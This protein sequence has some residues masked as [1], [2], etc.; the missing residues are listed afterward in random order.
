MD[1]FSLSFFSISAVLGQF[2][3]ASTQGKARFFRITFE[4]E[5]LRRIRLYKVIKAKFIM[6]NT[7]QPWN[8]GY[9][10]DKQINSG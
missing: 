3:D 9:M 2:L 1:S 10:R 6:S 8:P 7:P 5:H 4:M